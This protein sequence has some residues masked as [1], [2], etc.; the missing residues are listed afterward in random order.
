LDESCSVEPL[1]EA[2]KDEPGFRP[3]ALAALSALND[4]RAAEALRELFDVPSAET[5]Y[6]AFRALWAS[7]QRDAQMRGEHLGGKF[8]M[9]E[10]PSAGAPMVHVTHSFRP[11]IV[12]FG[13]GQEFTTPL[14][15]EAGNSIIVKSLDS[16]EISVAR[17]SSKEPD[18]RRT[19]KNSVAEVIRAIA[20]VGGDYPDAVQALQE[21]RA[22]G[23]L[24]SRFE[25]DA[26][27]EWGRTYDRNHRLA[28]DSAGGKQDATKIAGDEDAAPPAAGLQLPNLFGG[29]PKFVDSASGDEPDAIVAD[30]KPAAGGPK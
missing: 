19:V 20:A 9:H 27:P 12:L 29:A 21:A 26:I 7:S 8:W 28:H 3:Y 11:E 1:K 14:A 16:G 17:F 30:K 18:Q 25:V 5:R 2:A 4:I 24:P 15:I 10:V 23:A 22:E 6:G 13:E